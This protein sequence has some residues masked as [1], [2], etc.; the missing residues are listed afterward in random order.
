MFNYCSSLVNFQAPMNI[1][2]DFCVDA[3]TLL[4]HDSLMSIINNLT[5][6][7]GKTLDLGATNLAKLTDEEKAIATN[8]GW[9]LE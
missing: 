8:K 5:T 2:V 7:T 6:V 9:T 3:C 1:S 4:S